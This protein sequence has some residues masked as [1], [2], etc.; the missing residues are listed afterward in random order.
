MAESG[1]EG[2][3]IISWNALF[4]SAGMPKAVLETLTRAF[5]QELEAGRDR[6]PRKTEH[7]RQEFDARSAA[8][9]VRT[10][11]PSYVQVLRA[12]GVEPE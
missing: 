1:L 5:A 11:L 3:S 10:Q 8:T 9:L 4:G 12:A 6:I 2:F 7:S